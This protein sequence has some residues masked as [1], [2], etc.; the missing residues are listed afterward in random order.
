MKTG[1]AA[2]SRPLEFL[3]NSLCFHRSKETDSLTFNVRCESNLTIFRFNFPTYNYTIIK[4]LPP[5][6][7]FKYTLFASE[8]KLKI[9]SDEIFA[10][11]RE[12]NNKNHI[13]VIPRLQRWIWNDAHVD[14]EH[15]GARALARSN[16]A[17]LYITKEHSGIYACSVAGISVKYFINT[18]RSLSWK[19]FPAY[20]FHLSVLVNRSPSLALSNASPRHLSFFFLLSRAVCWMLLNIEH[21]S[22]KLFSF[23]SQRMWDQFRR[24]G[25]I[26]VVG[27]VLFIITFLHNNII[28][29]L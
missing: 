26:I 6:D 19:Y 9:R 14:K 17:R 28:I 3:S 10:N 21:L 8:T 23:F 1:N 7:P 25:N 27:N 13:E 18:A 29:I 11:P 5:R 16:T 24:R 4:F 15:W 22:R 20:C 2:T 12:I